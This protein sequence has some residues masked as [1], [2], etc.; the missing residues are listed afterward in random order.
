VKVP[1]AGVSLHVRDSGAGAP[2]LLL[3]GNPD[4]S[5]VWSYVLPHLVDS[6]RCLAPDLPGFGESPLPEDFEASPERLVQLVEE[7]VTGLDLRSPFHVVAH[8]LGAYA[9]LLWIS[10]APER[11]RSL[12][13]LNTA[14]ARDYRWHPWGR[15]WR[16]PILG[17][18]SMATMTE[19]FFRA[20]IRSRSPRIP[21]EYLRRAYRAASRWSTKRSVLRWYRAMD[22]RRLAGWDERL[23][24]SLP[25]FPAQVIWGERD[26]YAASS[27]ADRYG[28]PVHR[29]PDCGHWPQLESPDAVGALLRRFLDAATS[30]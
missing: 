4:T 10:G 6:Y 20:S 2:V 28:V 27:Y 22:Y 24:A 23:L 13:V 3:H 15:L 12:T 7:L 29:L 16:T 17:E 19:P 18:L 8:D 1:Y 30:R 5:D 21:D 25:R 9:A 26:P 11:V 14:F